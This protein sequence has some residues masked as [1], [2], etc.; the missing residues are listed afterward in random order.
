MG[1]GFQLPGHIHI[2]DDGACDELGEQRHIRAEGN[3]VSLGRD[4]APVYIHGVAQALKGIKA[5]ADGQRQLQQGHAQAGD[6]VEAADEEVGVL[7]H[8][9]QPHP[10]RNGDNQPDCFPP[11]G[12]RALDGETAQVEKGNGEHHQPQKLRF[13]PAVENQAGQEQHPVFPSPGREKIHPQ[14][15][16]E[17]VV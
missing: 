16:R 13:P 10:R 5:D 12:F 3:G 7:E 15:R 8:P 2:A 17:E 9:Q 14:H 11:P 1:A 4:A 6:G